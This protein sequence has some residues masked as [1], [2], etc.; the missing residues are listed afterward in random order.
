MSTASTPD[1]PV[2]RRKYSA[3]FKAECVRQVAAGARQ[4]QVARANGIS[5]ALLARWQQ[6]AS[7]AA[8]ATAKTAADQAEISRLRAQVRRLEQERDILK[9]VVTIF[10][11][12]LPS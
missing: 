1:T 7:T 3:A 2:S 9:K 5:P 10:S 6:L 12:T 11:P 4:S 8:V